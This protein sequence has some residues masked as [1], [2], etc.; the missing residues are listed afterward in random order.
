LFLSIAIGRIQVTERFS[1][2]LSTNQLEDLYCAALN[3]S[4]AVC[5]C[6]LLLI[7]SLTEGGIG[8]PQM[9]ILKLNG[10]LVKS[11]TDALE[12]KGELMK[13]KQRTDD[14]VKEFNASMGYLTALIGTTI[15]QIEKEQKRQKVLEWLWAG[16]YW[17]RH[18]ELRGLRV[19]DTGKWFL[20]ELNKWV[21]G[22][23]P[24]ICHGMRTYC[25]FDNEL[26]SAQLVPESHLSCGITLLFAN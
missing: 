19:L 15:L 26:I 7:M 25:L 9:P 14:A 4:T 21:V 22:S 20:E 16:H 23:G 10:V 6:L 12:G 3:L 2:V 8:E 5:E 17:Q 18:N 13:A 11:I 1:D 24:L